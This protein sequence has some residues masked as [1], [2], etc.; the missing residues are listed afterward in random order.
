MFRGSFRSISS[1]VIFSFGFISFKGG[2][3]QHFIKCLPSIFTNQTREKL[4]SYWLTKQ[5]WF[6]DVLGRRVVFQ[7]S[8]SSK[9]GPLPRKV[10]FQ[11][12]LPSKEGCLPRNV[13]FQG[14]LFSKESHLLQFKFLGRSD[15]WLFRNSNMLIS[16]F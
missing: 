10:A 11:G 3:D 8:S 16:I 7:G 5:V 15:H 13:V 4:A 2:Q 12:S 1:K 6:G 9:E 14:R